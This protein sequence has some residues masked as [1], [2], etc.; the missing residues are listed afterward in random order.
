MSSVNLEIVKQKCELPNGDLIVLLDREK[1]EKNTQ[2]HNVYRISANGSVQWQVAD[3]QTMPALSTFTNI[4]LIGE[5]I[6]AYN[7]D[8]GMY[9]VSVEDGSILGSELMR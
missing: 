9:K 6:E 7:F 1:V 2:Q 3:Y 5:Y 4:K 8:G